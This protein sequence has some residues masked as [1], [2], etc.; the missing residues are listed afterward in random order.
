MFFVKSEPQWISYAASDWANE[1]SAELL[2]AVTSLYPL[3]VS[4]DKIVLGVVEMG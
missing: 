2:E 3:E 1:Q 4:Y